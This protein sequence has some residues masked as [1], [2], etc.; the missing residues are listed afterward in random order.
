MNKLRLILLALLC[1]N[2]LNSPSYAMSLLGRLGIG[3][4]NQLV[5]GMETLSFKLQRNRSSAIGGLLGLNANQ[6]ATNYAIGAKFYRIIYDEP[7]LNFYT[8][9]TLATFSYQ[10]SENNE[11]ANGY[12][13]EAG[14]GSEFSF[15]GLESIGFSFEFGAGYSNYDGENTFKTVGHDIITSAIHFYL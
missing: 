12:Q 10:S 9:A 8:C 13:V 15:Q 4:N 1:V 6:D 14:L 5:T 3:M 11:T 7:Q 2:V